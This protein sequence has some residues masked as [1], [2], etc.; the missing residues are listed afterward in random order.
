MARKRLTAEQIIAKPRETP[1]VTRTGSRA[2][3]PT[4]CSRGGSQRPSDSPL[5]AVTTDSSDNL[6]V[7]MASKRPRNRISRHEAI[8]TA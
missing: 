8:Q 3:P 5:E 1:V 2:S 4:D 7:L 6:T